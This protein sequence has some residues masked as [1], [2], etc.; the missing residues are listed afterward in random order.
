MRTR[1]QS[2]LKG[3]SLT[4]AARASQLFWEMTH[5]RWQVP[6]SQSTC[7]LKWFAVVCPSCAGALHVWAI[8]CGQIF[9]KKCAWKG[10]KRWPLCFESL[11][12]VVSSVLACAGPTMRHMSSGYGVGRQLAR[13]GEVL[14]HWTLC[15]CP[16]LLLLESLLHSYG[17]V[18]RPADHCLGRVPIVC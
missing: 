5:G 14:G 1:S 6:H 9:G 15:R 7:L 10:I 13:G 3:A 4:I 8:A 11:L 17:Q 12:N 18:A 16:H 2:R